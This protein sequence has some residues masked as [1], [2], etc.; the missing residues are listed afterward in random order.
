MNKETLLNI[1]KTHTNNN[2]LDL[3]LDTLE[4]SPIT[5]QLKVFLAGESLILDSVTEPQEDGSA[6]S[7]S[8]T[9]GNGLFKGV[10][11]TARFIA[12]DPVHLILTTQ[13]QENWRLNN[14]FSTL[15]YTLADALFFDSAILQLSSQIVAPINQGLWFNGRLNLS[16]SLGLYLFLIGNSDLVF[17][18]QITTVQDGIP[19]MQLSTVVRDGTNLAFFSLGSISLRLIAQAIPSPRKS[20]IPQPRLYL[21]LV[22]SVQ[23]ISQGQLRSLPLIAHIYNPE[24]SIRLDADLTQGIDAALDEIKALINSVSINNISFGDFKLENVIKL[25]QLTIYV[26]PSTS[27]KVAHM[28]LCLKSAQSWTLL[29]AQSGQPL[30]TLEEISVKVGLQ[31]PF[32]ASNL[33]AYLEGQIKIGNGLLILSVAASAKDATLRGY[34]DNRSPIFLNDLM[35][36]FVNQSDTYT[37][38]L[39]INKFDILVQP[40]HH[41]ELSASVYDLWS[42]TL[43]DQKTLSLDEV[44]LHLSY[45]TDNHQTD[46]RISCLLGLGGAELS[47]IATYSNVEGWDVKGGLVEGQSIELDN[48]LAD[49]EYGFGINLPDF[50]YGMRLNTFSVHFNTSQKNFDFMIGGGLLIEDEWLEI[51][52]TLHVQKVTDRQES[53]HYEFGISGFVAITEFQFSLVF[54]HNS[55]S[56]YFLATYN[57]IQ[58]IYSKDLRPLIASISTTVA[59]YIPE[60]LE[61]EI[62]N[63]IFGYMESRF[64]FGLNIGT[65]INLSNLPLMGQEFPKDQTIGVD[66]LQFLIANKD[67]TSLEITAF[68]NL[69]EQG[70]KIPTKDSNNPTACA[71]P[72]G[73]NVVAKMRFGDTTNTLALPI[74][75]SIPQTPSQ[76]TLPPSTT[77]TSTSDNATWFKIQKTFGPVHFERVGVQ[78][79]DAA[80]GFLLDASLSLAGL[81]LS[82]DGLSVNSPL[83]KF[84][85]HFDLK[86]IGID[87]KGGESLE[88]GGA[89]LRTTR[90][91]IEQYDGAAIIKFNVKGKALTLSAI[92]SYAYFEGHPSLFIYALLNYPLGGPSFFFVTGLAAG[93]GYNRALKVPTIEQ[94]ATFPLVAE[95]V[96]PPPSGSNLDQA[97]RLTE[98]LTKL[99]NY[100]PPETG[101]IFLAIGV[102]FTSFKLIDAFVLLTI[103]FG[104]RF[105]LN[106]LGLATLIAPPDVGAGVPPVAQAQLALK[107][108]FL[109]AEGFLGIIA[110]LTPNSYIFSQAC[111]LTGGFAFYSW[112]AP[113]EHE[114]DFVLTLGGYHPLFKV[115]DYYPK[116]PRLSLNWQVSPELYIKADAYFALTA[117][118]LM[119]GGN[120]QATWNSGSL[121]AWFNAKADFIIAW[122]PYYYDISIYVDMGVSYTYHVFGTHHITVELGANLHIWG[123]E[124]T[125]IAHIH[126]WII[127]FDVRFGNSAAQAPTPIDWKTFK[128]SF[129]PA[130]SDICSI[131]VKEGLVRKVNQDDKLDLGIINPKDFCLVTNSVIP[132]KKAVYQQS[133]SSPTL[134]IETDGA[135]LEFGIA[136]MAVT[137]QDLNSRLIITINRDG[138]PL[139]SQQ[140]QEEFTCTPILKKVPVGLWGESLTPNLNGNQFVENTLAGFEIKPKKQPDSGATHAIDRSQLQGIP[141]LI[142]NAYQWETI[143]TFYEEKD[144][145]KTIQNTILDN[146]VKKAREA[147]LKALN[148]DI[149][150]IDISENIANEFLV[151]PKVGSLV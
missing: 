3:A 144:Q 134:D 82:L 143:K 102:K 117:S 115:P 122:K 73:L 48:I 19:I 93:F 33:S 123:P 22:S 70:T 43:H 126:L 84:D 1:L 81:S 66:D 90:N 36:H 72:K 110:Q 17:S 35:Q 130:D 13:A 39:R 27:T 26:N 114:G 42:I 5:Q 65:Q 75:S 91:G 148:L 116:V 103:A 28:A 18:G 98:E 49:L 132:A 138:K 111:H 87:Y 112:F 140:F 151:L 2:R 21:E 146:S 20:K 7:V 52:I 55:T 67:F 95:A 76:P 24:T 31:A 120:L 137:S 34:L 88:I 99:Q 128:N 54:L 141:D 61:I 113:S 79:K 124:F 145:K 25:T 58:D 62:K 30:V 94:V 85:P 71:L 109:P 101:Q 106:I 4:S 104:H 86:G 51:A 68:N 150:T 78:Y 53:Q 129:L 29:T 11:L 74:S 57:H 105:E 131:A 147:L 69:I 32:S 46:A 40:S 133:E 50:L 97:T 83:S 89:F 15:Q 63:A 8:G 127:S 80:I 96:N 59:Q 6:I 92:G 64:L 136:S 118:A 41:Y 9:S 142:N 56:N 14:S 121:R 139:T 23:F 10:K 44:E 119:V 149:E 16:S 77:T 100:I 60:E 47:M 135:N 45:T 38:S 125:G 108:S 37:P 107:A 12:G